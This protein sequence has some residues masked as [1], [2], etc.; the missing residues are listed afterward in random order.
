MGDIALG[1]VIVAKFLLC[2][3]IGKARDLKKLLKTAAEKVGATF[4]DSC[5]FDFVPPGASAT[6]LLQ[7]SHYAAHTWPKDQVVIGVF[8][9]CGT[10]DSKRAVE[11]ISQELKA[12]KVWGS[13]TY[14]DTQKIVEYGLTIKGGIK[15][16]I[17]QLD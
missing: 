16:H 7:E 12:E 14:L 11:F 3:E 15:W 17:R 5:S 13:I 8:Y 2:Q 6:I 1:N 10:I 4:L 9:T